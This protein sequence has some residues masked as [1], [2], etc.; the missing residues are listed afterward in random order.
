[1]EAFL[2]ATLRL[3]ETATSLNPRKL[4]Q[5]QAMAAEHTTVTHCLHGMQTLQADHQDRSKCY[6]TTVLL[7]AFTHTLQDTSGLDIHIDLG[8]RQ[9]ALCSLDCTSCSVQTALPKRYNCTTEHRIYKAGIMHRQTIHNP[10]LYRASAPTTCK[11][12]L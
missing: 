6:K 5:Q 1:V 2:V 9:V 3:L 12:I 11:C 8:S 4:A 10:A 7:N